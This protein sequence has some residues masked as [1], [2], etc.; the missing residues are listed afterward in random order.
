MNSLFKYPN[1][2]IV[3]ENYYDTS[4][5]SDYHNYI[6]VQN[7]MYCVNMYSN[8][9]EICILYD[10][11]YMKYIIRDCSYY[12]YYCSY[13]NYLGPSYRYNIEQFPEDKFYGAIKNWGTTLAIAV[14]YTI[15]TSEK[16]IGRIY[17]FNVSSS[18]VYGIKTAAHNGTFLAE[19]PNVFI[20]NNN[21][22]IIFQVQPS[23]TGYR[24]TFDFFDGN[25]ERLS[26]DDKNY[27]TA[28]STTAKLFK[29]ENDYAYTYMEY[30]FSTDSYVKF[31]EFT[32]IKI[33]RNES[34]VEKNTVGNISLQCYKDFLD[35]S[36]NFS[37]IDYPG[38]GF[39]IKKITLNSGMGEIHYVTQDEED[40]GNI[41]ESNTQFYYNLKF[42]ALLHFSY[43]IQAKIFVQAAP[44]LYIPSEIVKLSISYNPKPAIDLL[45][46]LLPRAE[47]LFGDK[48]EFVS[49]NLLLAFYKAPNANQITDANLKVNLDDNSIYYDAL[50]KANEEESRNDLYIFKIIVIPDNPGIQTE[51]DQ[52]SG[53]YHKVDNEFIECVQPEDIP[54]PEE[55][56]LFKYPI[57]IEAVYNLYTNY[58]PECMGMIYSTYR[59]KLCVFDNGTK[60]VND[61]NA[62]RVYTLTSM[63]LSYAS[64]SM[65]G[66][67]II[68][69]P[70]QQYFAYGITTYSYYTYYGYFYAN[71]SQVSSY[72]SMSRPSNAGNNRG[73]LVVYYSYN[74][75]F[76][77]L[78]NQGSYGK[79]KIFRVYCSFL[80]LLIFVFFSCDVVVFVLVRKRKHR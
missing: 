31:I 72:Y 43:T 66:F 14:V 79:Q 12:Q 3:G 13:G 74:Y 62:N 32:P 59:K 1:N 38:N 53:I 65:N 77:T 45:N 36:L 5:S 2:T 63:A 49:S 19:H 18:S 40:L 11:G 48:F 69:F 61:S 27:E 52:V 10:G 73:S 16:H 47:E 8:T 22:F 64:T 50:A 34:T 60:L 70:Q 54:A 78:Y 7:Q 30:Y 51:N 21:L 44:N 56:K 4:P 71:M 80:F 68:H 20:V 25:L 15:P 55:P 42:V 6:G 76:H 9:Y 29:F 35:N 57:K 23:S 17:R 28:T 24:S 58:A 75:Y 41:T 46:A 37:Y 26:I 39:Y 33:S 67:K